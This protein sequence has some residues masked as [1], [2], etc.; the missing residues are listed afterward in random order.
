MGVTKVPQQLL[1]AVKAIRFSVPG[2]CLVLP[3]LEGTPAVGADKALGMELV[4]HSCDDT[5]LAGLR[6]D[7][8]L[9]LGRRVVCNITISLISSHL[10]R[11]LTNE[12]HLL[13]HGSPEHI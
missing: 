5:T 9:V 11:N 1:K 8:A 7:T 12:L 10:I 4:P 2:I 3:L 13:Q 6:T